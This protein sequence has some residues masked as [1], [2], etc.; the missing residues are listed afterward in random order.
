MD[1]VIHLHDSTIDDVVHACA[2]TEFPIRFTE[3]RADFVSRLLKAKRDAVI[4]AIGA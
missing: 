1:R 4:A 2:A 3:R